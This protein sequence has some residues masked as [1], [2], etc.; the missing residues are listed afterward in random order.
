MRPNSTLPSIMKINF[1]AKLCGGDALLRVTSRLPCGN[2]QHRIATRVRISAVVAVGISMLF[3]SCSS[4]IYQ[5]GRHKNILKAGT[6][7]SAVIAELGEPLKSTVIPVGTVSGG[8]E[9]SKK[10]ARL[11]TYVTRDVISDR[12]RASGSGIFGE[13]TLGL[14]ELICLP[15]SLGHLIPREKT[16]GI[17]YDDKDMVRG[18]WVNDGPPKK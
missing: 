11:D 1:S 7:R 15:T 8:S 10:K 6:A 16:L 13:M 3:S 9:P 17:N 12:D 2:A 18:Y 4:M 14:S 5:T